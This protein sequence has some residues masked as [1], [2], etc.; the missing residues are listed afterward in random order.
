MQHHESRNLK[1]KKV[2][3]NVE[4]VSYHAIEWKVDEMVTRWEITLK[5]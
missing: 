1:S 4:A 2:K 5:W 3:Y